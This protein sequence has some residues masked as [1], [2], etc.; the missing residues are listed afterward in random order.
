MFKCWMVWVGL[1]TTAGC[2]EN[3]ATNGTPLVEVN[4]EAI[5]QQQIEEELKTLPP[6]AQQAYR[7]DAK[8]FVEQRVQRTVLLQEAR[9]RGFDRSDAVKAERIP[10]E[11]NPDEVLIRVL[12]QDVTK[13]VFVS[14]EEI[15]T[16]IRENRDRFPS[17]DMETLRPQLA[18]FILSEKQ[19][20]AMDFWIENQVALS[21]IV[22]NTA[23]LKA[24]EKGQEANPLDRALGSGRPV[25]ADFGR[26]VCI[27]CKKMQPILED[28]ER[29]YKGKAEVLIIEID[30]Y[31]ALT[32]RSKVRM[33]PTQIF[34]DARGNEVYRHEG[35]MGREAMVDKFREMGVE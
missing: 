27:P 10:P 32:R 11:V 19:Q 7:E 16:F 13:D 3:Q 17:D 22:W 1:L 35:F 20:K 12:V 25:L 4:G 18:S 5:T 24:H 15:Q 28:L 26:G 2:G 30:E 14:E 33:I 23:W 31:R 29:E 6:Q 8:G 34:F 21:K 9:K